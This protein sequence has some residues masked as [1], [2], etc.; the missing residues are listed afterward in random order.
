MLQE[1]DKLCGTIGRVQLEIYTRQVIPNENSFIGF[2][3]FSV[4]A[5]N[6]KVHIV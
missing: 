5:D 6:V 2:L 4:P 3:Y 1:T